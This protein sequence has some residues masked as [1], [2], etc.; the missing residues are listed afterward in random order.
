MADKSPRQTASKKSGK[1]IKEKRA[2]K[3][4]A[5]APASSIDTTPGKATKK[6]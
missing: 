4:A 5:A 1:S 2:D 6:K 3:R